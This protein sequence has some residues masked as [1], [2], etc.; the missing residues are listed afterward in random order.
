M[1]KLL[2]AAQLWQQLIQQETTQ[3]RIAAMQATQAEAEALNM[4][5]QA[6]QTLQREQQLADTSLVVSTL[7]VHYAEHHVIERA[8]IAYQQ[9]CIAAENARAAARE[10]AAEERRR[11]EIT[12]VLRRDDAAQRLKKEAQHLEELAALHPRK[13]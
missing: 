6:Q 5:Q 4:L 2:K 8:R 11:Q 10:A 12:D 13:K 9:A 7:W 1:N 3:V